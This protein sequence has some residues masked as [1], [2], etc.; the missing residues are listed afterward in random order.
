MQLCL[1]CYSSSVVLPFRD[2]RE[3]FLVAIPGDPHPELVL[4]LLNYLICC[5]ADPAVGPGVG[6]EV[7]ED[8]EL[9]T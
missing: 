4:I 3:L 9:V 1:S 2:L 7:W 6:V 5:P 8:V